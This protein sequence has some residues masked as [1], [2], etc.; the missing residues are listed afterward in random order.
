M[1]PLTHVYYD[2]I[3]NELVLFESSLDSKYRFTFSNG[4]TLELNFK[5]L[6]KFEDRI[7]YEYIG[8]LDELN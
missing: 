7:N 8:V 2:K 1:T 6:D 4:K 5:D 3:K